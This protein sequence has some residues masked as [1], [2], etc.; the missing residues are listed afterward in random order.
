MKTLIRTLSLRD[1]T[2]LIIGLVIGSGIFLVPV[3]S[4]S[5]SAWFD[6]RVAAGSGSQAE[7][8]RCSAR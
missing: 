4:P 6:R 7:C 1:L 2:L 8:C 5:R 3:P